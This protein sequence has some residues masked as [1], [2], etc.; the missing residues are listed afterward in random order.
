G[1]FDATVLEAC[2]PELETWSANVRP[3]TVLGAGA[4][5]EGLADLP[6]ARRLTSPLAAVE[7]VQNDLH[8]FREQNQLD[9][10]VVVNV[11][12]TEPPYEFGEVHQSLENLSAA[13]LRDESVL[14]ASSLYAYAAI[15]LGLPYVNFT[16]SPGATLPALQELALKRQA[17]IA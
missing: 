12:S 6:E 4:T 7:R 2:Q 16:P 15:D 3:G 9:Q 8:R 10:V 1:V 5:I 14:P 13:L 17:P 11:A